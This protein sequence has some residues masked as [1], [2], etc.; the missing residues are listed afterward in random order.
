MADET[1]DILIELRTDLK[2]LM[3]TVSDHGEKLDEM[4]TQAKLTN[5]RVSRLED[6][7]RGHEKQSEGCMATVA[8]LDKWKQRGIGIYL[9]VVAVIGAVSAFAGYEAARR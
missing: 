4:V 6:W 9:F 8:G 7:Q 5:G 3:S 1:R 2:W